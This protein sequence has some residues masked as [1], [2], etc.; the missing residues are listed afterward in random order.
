MLYKKNL[1]NL[2]TEPVVG[3]RL[4]LKANKKEGEK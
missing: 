3:Q 1:M 4:W 2:G